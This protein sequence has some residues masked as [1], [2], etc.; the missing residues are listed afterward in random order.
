M[1]EYNMDEQMKQLMEQEKELPE[2]LSFRL[3]Q[4]IDTLAAEEEKQKNVRRSLRQRRYTIGGVAAAVAAAFL[5]FF[6][7]ESRI[8][9]PDD[10]FDN[11]EEAALAAYEALGF[12][13]QQL[14]KGLEPLSEAG[15]E[16]EKVNKIL[17]KQFNTSEYE[18]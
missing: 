18:N 4:Y 9:T 11:P 6:Q 3:E 15:K 7:I 16:V 8:T 2:G 5:L 12:L 13:S 14:N 1:K 17:D 10:T